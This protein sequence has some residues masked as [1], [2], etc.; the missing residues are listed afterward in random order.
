LNIQLSKTSDQDVGQDVSQAAKN[1][2]ESLIRM[3]V[4]SSSVPAAPSG[5]HKNEIA[6]KGKHREKNQLQ[7]VGSRKE[8]KISGWPENKTESRES[9]PWE[10]CRDKAAESI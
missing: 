5:A 10:I 3:E 8:N 9:S 2:I 1:S 4:Y 7:S 6:A